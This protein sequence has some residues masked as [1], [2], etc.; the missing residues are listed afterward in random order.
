[1]RSIPCSRQRRRR[2]AAWC[3]ATPP[4]ALPRSRWSTVARCVNFCSNDYLGLA[5]D[6]RL[7]R[8]H[9]GCRAALGQRAPAPRTWSPA[10]RAEHHALEEE[11]AAFTG[12]EAALLFSTGYMAN[13]GVI[14]AL[15]AR[16]EVVLQD[17]LNHASLLDG[18]RLSD[19][20]RCSAIGMPTRPMRSALLQAMRPKVA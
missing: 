14:S 12:R 15:A 20:R 9:A 17:R 13:V 19:A 4:A 11:L 6:A 2:V 16:G 1:M 10:T 8:G 3:R 7:G 18:A 5:R